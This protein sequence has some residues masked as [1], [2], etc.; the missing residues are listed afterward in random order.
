MCHSFV[1]AVYESRDSDLLVHV[2]FNSACPLH[3]CICSLIHSCVSHSWVHV[4][5]I[6]ACVIHS[7]MLYT[8][9]VIVMHSCMS[10]SSVHVSFIRA[11]LIHECMSDS[12]V[13]VWFIRACV[14]HSCM[15]YTNHVI[16][17]HE[18]MSSSLVRVCVMAHACVS[19]LVRICMCGSSR[20]YVSV[21]R[22]EC[23]SHVTR[24]YQPCHTHPPAPMNHV[25]YLRA[26]PAEMPVQNWY[27]ANTNHFHLTDSV[28]WK[29]TR[30]LYWVINPVPHD[31]VRRIRFWRIKSPEQDFKYCTER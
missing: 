6:R 30:Q 17:I 9:H 1:H 12:W 23:V 5:F 26:S 24:M 7:C 10:S 15:L 20:T 28:R 25:K 8:N 31:L 27:T 11:C 18:C 4:W 3:Q 22:H 19:H 16:V 29:S 21:M 14:I 2:F 13:H